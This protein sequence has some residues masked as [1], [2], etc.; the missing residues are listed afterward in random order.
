MFCILFSSQFPKVSVITLLSYIEFLADNKYSASSVKNYLSACKIKFKQL[1]LDVI[2]FESNLI[3]FALKSLECNSPNVYKVKAILS[4]TEIQLVYVLQAHPL[5]YM[6]RL[7][8]LLGFMRMLRIS[9]VVQVS[10][11]QFNK[12]RH[13]AMNKNSAKMV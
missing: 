13:L 7:A 10:L 6:Y 9:N 1:Q 11:A 3:K 4:F 8:I 2:A 5:F 12:H